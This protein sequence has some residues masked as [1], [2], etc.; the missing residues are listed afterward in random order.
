MVH[1]IEWNYEL[2]RKRTLNITVF[3]VRQ[4]EIRYC[5]GSACVGSVIRNVLKGARGVGKVVHVLFP[6]MNRTRVH[7]CL[8]EV[9]VCVGLVF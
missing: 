8:C 2:I 7:G 9:S 3:D 5:G 4:V 6:S 1:E